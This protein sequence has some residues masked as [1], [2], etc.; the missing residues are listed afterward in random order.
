MGVVPDTLRSWMKQAA[1][2][3]GDRPGVSTVEASL[4]NE[5]E[6]EVRELKIA[7]EILLAAS[8]FFAGSRPATAVA[9]VFV[10]AQPWID[11][12]MTSVVTGNYID[13]K[14]GRITF[15]AHFA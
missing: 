14:A 6:S 15:A 10:D 11:E 13:P 5:L 1:V 9:I 7:N 3:A 12:V 8:S 2:D 4:V